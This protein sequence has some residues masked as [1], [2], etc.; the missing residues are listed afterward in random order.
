MKEVIEVE[1]KKFTTV[2]IYKNRYNHVNNF[3]A[4]FSIL[5]P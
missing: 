1:K 4:S 3:G 2:I 5:V